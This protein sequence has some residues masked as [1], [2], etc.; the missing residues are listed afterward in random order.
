MVYKPN[1]LQTYS[2]YIFPGIVYTNVYMPQIVFFKYSFT[3]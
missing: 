2:L 3:P 1:K